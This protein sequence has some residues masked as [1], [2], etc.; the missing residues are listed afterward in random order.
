MKEQTKITIIEFRNLIPDLELSSI[1]K[2]LAFTL[3]NYYN[4]NREIYPSLFSLEQAMSCTRNTVIAAIKELEQNEIIEIYK[5]RR[6]NYPQMNNHYR[7][8]NVTSSIVELPTALPDALP[9]ALPDAPPTALPDAPP[10]ALPDAPPTILPIIPPI[11]GITIEPE[12]VIKKLSKEEIKKED[13]SS[14]PKGSRFIKPSISEI[15]LYIQ[16]KEYTFSAEE[17]YNHYESVDWFRGKAKI[18]NWRAVCATWQHNQ[19]KGFGSKKVM[20][21]K[22]FEG[23]ELGGEYDDL[24]I[25]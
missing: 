6:S 23:Q 11:N 22:D 15:S 8:L 10:T 3:A 9:T 1:A 17:F 24:F 4:P 21:N 7:L 5:K 13:K 20:S 2:L 25:R 18:N 14:S 19:K 12:L 16:E